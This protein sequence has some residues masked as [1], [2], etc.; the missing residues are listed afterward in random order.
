MNGPDQSLPLRGGRS[1]DA[2]PRG[3]QYAKEAHLCH[4]AHE[5]HEVRL[6]GKDPK[7]PRYDQRIFRERFSMY[8]GQ[9][10][11]AGASRS[12]RRV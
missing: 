4:F 11:S 2:H 8:C 1:I 12:G 3:C 10:Y 9:D 5:L 7:Y 6:Q